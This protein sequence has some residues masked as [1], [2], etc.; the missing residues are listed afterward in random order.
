[1]ADPV[2]HH[3]IIVLGAGLSGINTAH[4]LRKSLPHRSFTI[5]EGRAVVGGTWSFFRYPG[6]RSDSYMTAFGFKWHPWTHRHKMADAAEI[7]EYIEAAVDA[8]GLRDKIRFEH[9]V[10]ACEW[11]SAEQQWRL[12]VDVKGERRIIAANFVISCAG[13]YAY[14]KAFETVIPGLE[15]FGGQVAHPQWWPEDLDY[16]G[17]RVVVIGS[18][19]TAVTI[20]PS[21]VEKAASVTMVQRSPSF[22][23]SRPTGSGVDDFLRLVLPLAWMQWIVWW[24]DT[25][26]EVIMTQF[27]LKFP[28]VG[29]YFLTKMA[30]EQLPKRVDV[31]VHF[32]PSYNVFQQRLCMCPDGDFFKALSRDNCEIITDAI[33]TVIEDGLLMESGRKLPAD[34]IVTATGLYFQLFGGLVPTVDGHPID[35]GSHYVWRGCMLDSLPNTAFI[36]GYITQSWTPGAEVMAQMVVKVLKHMEKT[37]STSAMPVL[38]AATRAAPQKLAVDATSNYFI[39]AAE[40]VPKVT[41]KGV[42]YGRTNWLVDVWAWLF[43][44]V[45]EGMVYGR[46]EEKKQA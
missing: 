15:S 36:M 12:D 32:N 22:V 40:R 39:K 20:V 29:R 11:R 30:K 37:G 17:K 42:W 26:M 9:R 2:E 4:V 34:I 6:F 45:T 27:L 8:E 25:L 35:A 38:D 28:S 3:D 19:A 44:S 24:K 1:M 23:V 14:D 5:L 21:L 10:V 13:Y 31:D 43:G 33:E 46:R 16:T 7:V 41:G 18:G